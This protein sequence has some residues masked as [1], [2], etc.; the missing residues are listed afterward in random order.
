MVSAILVD[1][2]DELRRILELNPDG[3][4]FHWTLLQFTIKAFDRIRIKFKTE[5]PDAYP[6]ELQAKINAYK[7]LAVMEWIIR[8][9]DIDLP[10]TRRLLSRIFPAKSESQDV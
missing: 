10:E 4:T 8:R 7:L 1:H 5:N 6:P 3:S 2:R 9:G